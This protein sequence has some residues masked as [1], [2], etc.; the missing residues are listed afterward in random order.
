MQPVSLAFSGRNPVPDAGKI[1]DRE[2]GTSAFGFGNKLFGDVVVHPRLK[3]VLPSGQFFQSSFAGLRA[4][5]LETFSPV[6]IPEA[7]V[8]DGGSGEDFSVGIGGDV[9]DSVVHPEDVFGKLGLLLRDVADK[10]D[11]PLFGCLGENEI[12]FAFPEPE[13]FS[14]MFPADE[15][16]LHASGKRPEADLIPL[17]EG[18]DPVVVGLR[19][20]FPE[21]VNGRPVRPVGIGHL[22]DAPDDHLGG[23][24]RRIPDG[25]IFRL[26]QSELPEGLRLEGESGQLVAKSVASLKRLE[27]DLRLIGCRSKFEVD[28]DLH[29]DNSILDDNICQAE[30]GSAFLPGLNAGV[31]NAR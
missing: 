24:R 21:E 3:T 4:F 31:S 16:D 27:E 26:V 10:I 6:L 15:G 1:F 29:R 5:L 22:G 11:E 9:D 25:V 30:R 19:G 17:L 18:K 7:L 23:E 2:S 8:L 12:H 14:L 28:S 13:I 20:P